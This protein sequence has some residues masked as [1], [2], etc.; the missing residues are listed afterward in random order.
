MLS[1]VQTSLTLSHYTYIHTHTVV[2]GCVV[3]ILSSS[4]TNTRQSSCSLLC[5]GGKTL[6]RTTLTLREQHVRGHTAC[7]EN[8]PTVGRE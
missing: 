7:L 1:M 4:W 8:L 6:L 5:G 2:R 3:G